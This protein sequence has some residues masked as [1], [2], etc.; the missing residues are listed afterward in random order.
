MLV[1]LAAC[2]CI[3][4]PQSVTPGQT[5]RRSH[6]RIFAVDDGITFSGPCYSCYR[7][8]LIFPDFSLFFLIF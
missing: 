3:V 2:G 7:S 5:P 4:Y 6:Q 8:T 1:V